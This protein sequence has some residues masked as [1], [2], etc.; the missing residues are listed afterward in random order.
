MQRLAE[1]IDDETEQY[2]LYEGDL[3]DSINSLSE[4]KIQKIKNVMKISKI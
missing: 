3:Q 1:N 2:N 4:K